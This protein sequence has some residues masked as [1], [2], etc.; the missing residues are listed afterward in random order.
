MCHFTREQQLVGRS[1]LL[2]LPDEP[3]VHVLEPVALV[4]D[5][6]PPVGPGQEGSVVHRNFVRSHKHILH[7]LLHARD[8]ERLLQLLATKLLAFLLKRIVKNRFFEVTS[9]FLPFAFRGTAQ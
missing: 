5:N 1:V 7:L 2:E 3:A 8:L 4:D 6:V 9:F